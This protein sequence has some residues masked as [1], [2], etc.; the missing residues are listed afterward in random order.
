MFAAAQRFI[1]LALRIASA[2]LGQGSCS[3]AYQYAPRRLI[4]C[5][6]CASNC[7]AAYC[8]RRDGPH[9]WII[10]H[11]FDVSFIVCSVFGAWLHC[12]LSAAPSLLLAKTYSKSRSHAREKTKKL[13]KVFARIAAILQ[14]FWYGFC[15][16]K[17]H[18][19]T[20]KK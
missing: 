6:C 19:K 10:H 20:S 4:M 9:F 13:K 5:C 12:L 18:A 3:A 1:S 15:Y 7:A 14:L 2:R 17:P 11:F 16:S 8:G